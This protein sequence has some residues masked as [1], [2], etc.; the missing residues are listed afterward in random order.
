MLT[1]PWRRA[2]ATCN[3]HTR[4]WRTWR[5]DER[6][7]RR[8]NGALGQLELR[9][10]Q[11][12]ARVERFR[13]T[14]PREGRQRG[15]SPRGHRRRERYAEDG[16]RGNSRAPA[17]KRNR[18]PLRQ[19][20]AHQRRFSLRERTGRGCRGSAPLLSRPSRQGYSLVRT[21]VR[22]ADAPLEAAEPQSFHR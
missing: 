22:D 16:A 1:F 2:R 17:R 19:R 21:V 13:R 6:R 3:R 10:A 20:A 18:A 11:A 4:R 8:R 7:R 12:R 15:M 14:P 5:H 9:S